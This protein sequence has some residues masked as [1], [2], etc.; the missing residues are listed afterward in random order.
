M[1][2]LFIL[3]L[4]MAGFSAPR[5]D[6]LWKYDYQAAL[7]FLTENRPAIKE[8]FAGSALPPQI[9]ISVVFPELI[10]Y[11]SIR[12]F[13]E[14]RALEIAYVRHGLDAV[15]FSIGHFQMKPSFVAQIEY[16]I[17]NSKLSEKYPELPIDVTLN[18]GKRRKIRIDRLKQVK[19]QLRYL[20]AFA[21]LLY[22]F[23][24][25]IKKQDSTY[26]VA[27]LA[28]AYNLGYK[29]SRKA[30]EKWMHVRSFP[31]GREAWAKQY[32]YADVAVYFY[33]HHRAQIATN[34]IY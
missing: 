7:H 31:D 30:I 15:D 13:I 21:D 34:H 20:S 29:A 8:V 9:V 4:V 18:V 6:R 22:R 10:R 23:H 12:N 19:W 27:F 32:R 26:Q 17:V 2:M 33:Q 25:E 3:S 16:D 24:P 14:T 5:Y 1:K 11:N 28:S